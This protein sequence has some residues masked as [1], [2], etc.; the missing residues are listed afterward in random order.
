MQHQYSRPK[1]KL[2]DYFG[3]TLDLLNAYIYELSPAAKQLRKVEEEKEKQRSAKAWENFKDGCLNVLLFLI[4]ASILTIIYVRIRRKKKA[5]REALEEAARLKKDEERR[6][7]IKEREQASL[8]K[9]A[10]ETLKRLPK[11]STLAEKYKHKATEIAEYKETRQKI[12]NRI[13]VN[14]TT[15]LLGLILA[16]E[17][18]HHKITNPTS[19]TSPPPS[20]T[21][22]PK[23]SASQKDDSEEKERLRKK[24]QREEEEEEEERRRRRRR[25]EDES[26]S[27]S[28][29]ILG[30][31]GSSDSG[32]GFSS[33]SDF[34]GGSFGGGGGGSDW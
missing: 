4:P 16:L 30:G 8:L 17:A 19:Y 33:G 2:G 10:E 27:S 5:K 14:N 24:K 13:S 26:S 34:G 7:K 23:S 20:P 29:S 6:A 3:G 32:G 28:S 15:T 11:S 18:L 1:F 12:R 9:R 31:F 22:K 21:P 25:E